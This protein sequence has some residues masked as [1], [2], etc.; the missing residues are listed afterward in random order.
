MST[1][2]VV[3]KP[4]K[5]DLNLKYTILTFIPADSGNKTD[6]TANNWTIPFQDHG[7]SKKKIHFGCSYELKF[8][9]FPH[10]IPKDNYTVYRLI[11]I[12]E[13]I[14][15][16][17]NCQKPLPL[18]ENLKIQTYNNNSRSLLVSWTYN[19]ESTIKYFNITCSE[20]NLQLS[21]GRKQYYK[22]YDSVRI[23]YTRKD[24]KYQTRVSLSNDSLHYKITVKA[25]DAHL[26]NA[27]IDA[28]VECDP[29][30]SCYC[31][32]PNLLIPSDIRI[33]SN[34][35]ASATMISWNYPSSDLKQ[36]NHFLVSFGYEYPHDHSMNEVEKFHVPTPEDIASDAN[37]SRLINMTLFC[38]AGIS[39][40]SIVNISAVDLQGCR[41]PISKQFSFNCY[42]FLVENVKKQPHKEIAL[43]F[44]LI[45]LSM[46]IIIIFFIAIKYKR[47]LKIFI[48]KKFRPQSHQACNKP[49]ELIRNV[50]YTEKEI[51]EARSKGLADIFE[52][53]N[54]RLLLDDANDFEIRDFLE[55][56][57]MMK[58]VGHHPNIITMIACC[59][60]Q[61]PYCMVME[62]VSG[63]DLLHYLKKLRKEYVRRSA[64]FY[65]PCQQKSLAPTFF[66]SNN[67]RND[68]SEYLLRS[69]SS[70]GTT[71]HSVVLTTTSTIPE[72]DEEDTPT[73]ESDSLINIEPIIATNYVR[74]GKDGFSPNLERP[75]LTPCCL[76]AEE[77]HAFA[78]QIA[79]GMNHLAS[80]GITH[81][82][83]AARNVLIDEKNTL[84]I[85]DFGLSR[86]G[87]YVTTRCA[88][89]PLRWLSIEAIRDS[90][91]TTK[92]D[93][94]AF[95][96]VLWEICTLG[97]FPYASVPDSAFP[98]YLINGNR[99]QKPDNCSEEIYLIMESCWNKAPYLRPDFSDLCESLESMTDISHVYV[100]FDIITN[101][102][103]P[104]EQV[105]LLNS[106]HKS[107]KSVVK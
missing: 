12:P 50:I 75:D 48:L 63:G 46:V 61:Q 74:L 34:I 3:K 5:M 83:L 22:K 8:S 84:K 86:T 9:S 69:Q 81:R 64:L 100:N 11:R 53:S 94:W 73:M 16:D 71:N 55:E 107:D 41:G 80:K 17:C 101:H 96:V 39:A 88:K 93:V 28:L 49:I 97:G 20:L 89:V 76:D 77:L 72:E 24:T 70:Y 66:S 10:P 43:S 105:V 59:T 14:Q 98:D 45:I 42:G 38:S 7:V 67:H 91:Y 60:L 62:Y 36:V 87:V 37:V 31:V 58:Q 4:H 82:D 40:V 99:L 79:K 103:L 33:I 92:S 68:S 29:K 57:K 106:T 52:I 6:F 18:V 1:G 104:P 95:G 65:P 19:P 26:C 90:L 102:P 85:S 13:C 27:S 54:C 56:I 15:E 35:S 51:V 47:K 25:F 30:G 23:K 2:H 21:S 78:L 32:A 44:G